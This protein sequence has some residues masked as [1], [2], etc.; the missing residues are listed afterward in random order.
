MKK[1]FVRFFALALVAVMMVCTLASCA[2][3]LS[4]SYVAEV[5][6]ELAGYTATYT[7]SG[8]NV[9]VKKEATIAGFSKTTELA[10]TYEI[11]EN[12]NG[13]LEI[14]LSFETDDDE[15]KSGTFAFSEGE[16]NGVEYIKIG[17]VKYTLV[18]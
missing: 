11:A 1:T 3:K 5:G 17:V 18:K 13:E 12:E 4:G 9:N 10:G 15:I 2:K 8:K 7:F 16:E 14:T 6:G